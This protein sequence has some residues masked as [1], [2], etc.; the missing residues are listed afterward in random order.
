MHGW[1]YMC[2]HELTGTM[3]GLTDALFQLKQKVLWDI[4]VR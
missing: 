1:S 3:F 2:T 4:F